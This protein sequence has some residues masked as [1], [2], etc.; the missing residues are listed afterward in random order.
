M[1]AQPQ[2]FDKHSC[3]QFATVPPNTLN[4]RNALV[5]P[6]RFRPN[7]AKFRKL[8]PNS[9]IT[10][11]GP[12]ALAGVVSVRSM[13]TVMFV[14]EELSTWPIS[15]LVITGTAPLFVWVTLFTSQV[16]LGTLAGTR[17]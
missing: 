10:G 3:C 2:P 16:T 15:C 6:G 13:F 12:G 7:P 4:P 17:P 11:T 5:P 8:K 9:N 14:S 1:T